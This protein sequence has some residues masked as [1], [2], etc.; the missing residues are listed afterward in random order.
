[1]SNF[2][3]CLCWDTKN[4]SPLV[5]PTGFGCLHMGGLS[6]GEEDICR[7]IEETKMLG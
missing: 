2:P 5:Q 7:K 6:L 4:M 3:L 1:M